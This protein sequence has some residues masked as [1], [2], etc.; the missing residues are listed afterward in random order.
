MHFLHPRRINY[1]TIQI[2]KLEAV[3]VIPDQLRGVLEEIPDLFPGKGLP[4]YM[5]SQDYFPAKDCRV[6]I[7]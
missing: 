4:G 5:Y 1:I 3:C 2:Q 6:T 7:F